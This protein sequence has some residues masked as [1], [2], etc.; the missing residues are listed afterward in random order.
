M[1]AAAAAIILTTVPMGT[2]V[3][4]AGVWL[5]T[6]L[7]LLTPGGKAPGPTC[8]WADPISMAPSCPMP[9][10]CE[11]VIWPT[12]KFALVITDW[13]LESGKPTTLGTATSWLP[14]LPLKPLEKLGAAPNPPGNPPTR[15]PKSG[16]WVNSGV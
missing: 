11:A 6:M 3:P 2:K 8:A 4:A 7:E 14:P 1:S 13:A 16:A 5:T 9:L 10:C 15:P 12:V